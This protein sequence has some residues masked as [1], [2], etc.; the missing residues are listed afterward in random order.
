M[1]LED[2]VC[3]EAVIVTID[4]TNAAT[5]HRVDAI[6]GDRIAVVNAWDCSR[7]GVKRNNAGNGSDERKMKNKK[8][9]KFNNK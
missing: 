1:F 7:N 9:Q 6:Y 3:A 8:K 2:L 5:T 4:Q